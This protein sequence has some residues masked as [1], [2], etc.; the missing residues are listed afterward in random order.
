MLIVL[1]S[2]VDKRFSSYLGKVLQDDYIYISIRRQ[3]WL[4]KL[5]D[6][7]KENFSL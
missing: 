4:K 5:K 7:L 1:W 6:L 2:K 3:T